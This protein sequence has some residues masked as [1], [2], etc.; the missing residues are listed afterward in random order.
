M[1]VQ[2]K[3]GSS[4][5]SNRAN[6]FETLARD[7]NHATLG[8]ENYTYYQDAAGTPVTSPVININGTAQAISIPAA[9]TA[10]VISPTVDMRVSDTSG[11]SAGYF[12]VYAKTTVEIPV[13]TPGNDPND[14]T[15]KLWLLNDSGAGNC[16]FFFKC[17]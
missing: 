15:G 5:T 1:A 4:P 10:I 11:M 16:S 12:V 13:V 7:T 17:V 14:N 2:A 6:Q 3:P 8:K 9:A